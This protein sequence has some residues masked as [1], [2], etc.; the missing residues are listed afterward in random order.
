VIKAKQMNNFFTSV[1]KPEPQGNLPI[2]QERVFDEELRKF[3]IRADEVLKKLT[4]LDPRKSQGPDN[5][6]PKLLWE[7]RLRLA[8]LLADLFNKSL[9]E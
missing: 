7:L 1:F 2:F 6:H 8:P 5:I 3:E 4:K 9:E